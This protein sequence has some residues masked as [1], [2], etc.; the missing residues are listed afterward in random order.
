MAVPVVPGVN[1]PS[2]GD[3]ARG[4]LVNPVVSQVDAGAGWSTLADAATTFQKVL[5]RNDLERDQIKMADLSGQYK[6]ETDE[7]IRKLDPSAADHAERVKEIV[8]SGRQAF[9]DRL[10]SNNPQ[11]RNHF[12]AS[13]ANDGAALEMTAAGIR[14][15]HLEV[16]A[17]Q[18]FDRE[19]ERVYERIRR[20]P[21]GF[22]DYV[23]EFNGASANLAPGMSPTTRL[24]AAKDFYDGALEAV[25]QG[26]TKNGD[27]G[28]ATKFLDDNQGSM[29]PEKYQA[30]KGRIR[31]AVSQAR[32]D[33]DRAQA[34]N[35]GQAEIKILTEVDRIRKEGGVYGGRS[36]DEITNDPSYSPAQKASLIRMTMQAQQ[37]GNAEREDRQR[38]LRTYDAG[39]GVADRGE[40][41]KLVAIL[42]DEKRAKLVK[43]SDLTLTDTMDTIVSVAKR[44][45]WVSTAAVSMIN[46]ADN[47]ADPKDPDAAAKLEAAATVYQRLLAGAPSA[48][49]LEL[50]D[51]SRVRL[52]QALLDTGGAA[53][54]KEAAKYVAG[55]S[56]TDMTARTERNKEFPELSKQLGVKREDIN[57]LF[58]NNIFT[59]NVGGAPANP[60]AVPPEVYADYER[61]AKLQYAVSGRMDLADAAAKKWVTENYGPTTVG[62]L[63]H[64]VRAPAEKTLFPNDKLGALDPATRARILEDII[65]PVLTKS[66]HVAP[67][68]TPT[69]AINDPMTFIPPAGNRMGGVY[70]FRLVP[71][72]DTISGRSAPAY[73][74]QTPFPG[75][76]PNGPYRNTPAVGGGFMT[77]DADYVAKALGT[78]GTYTGIVDRERKALE[79]DRAK[80]QFQ[81]RARRPAPFPPNRN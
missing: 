26:Y 7:K 23:A 67:I 42:N 64:I 61:V 32:S 43:G 80:G 60:A 29:A 45:G 39:T 44:T 25:V 2:R 1:L 78:S 33:Y 41:D 69:P 70:G 77:I 12:A 19:R 24:K 71:T 36:I 55:L 14:R 53:S 59:R 66:G 15:G 13:L 11:I 18:V 35:Y 28:G 40:A 22:T 54:L 31:E 30:L 38:L 3:N 58:T 75:A 49:G 37:L 56:A 73:Y 65:V 8:T 50:K 16:A 27:F 47:L 48:K 63:T 46:G 6:V 79:S 57:A 9:V 5:Q 52:V 81:E 72:P 34:N 17:V 10:G 21:K 76:G 62:G 68:N 51:D 4:A 20:D 74:V